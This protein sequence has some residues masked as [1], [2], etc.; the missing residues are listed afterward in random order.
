MVARVGFSATIGRKPRQARKGAT[1]AVISGAGE[2]PAR[3]ASIK[4]GIGHCHDPR[5]ADRT[6]LLVGC[7]PPATLR[8]P[9][10]EGG[11]SVAAP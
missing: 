3:A 10:G 1:V 9:D 5:Q 11:E 7:R 2:A 6:K 4:R 8:N